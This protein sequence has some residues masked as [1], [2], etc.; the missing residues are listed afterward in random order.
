MRG[1]AKSDGGGR[2]RHAQTTLPFSFCPSVH[3]QPA[4]WKHPTKSKHQHQK[5]RTKSR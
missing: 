3:F 5:K 1:K 2:D 4:Q